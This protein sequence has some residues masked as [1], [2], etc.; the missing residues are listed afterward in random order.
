MQFFMTFFALLYIFIRLNIWIIEYYHIIINAI[1]IA[2]ARLKA[3][4]TTDREN[5]AYCQV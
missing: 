2:L 5:T 3:V 1:I 4:Y